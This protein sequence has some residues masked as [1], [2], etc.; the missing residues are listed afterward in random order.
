MTG[1]RHKLGRSDRRAIHHACLG[2]EIRNPFQH[3]GRIESSRQL[4]RLSGR[5]IDKALELDQGELDF[6][7]RLDYGGLK[8]CPLDLC[9]KNVV[10]RGTS[11]SLELLHLLETLTGK[12]ICGVLDS[13]ERARKQGLEIRALHVD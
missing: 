13:R 2:L 9:A 5:R 11:R 12:R 1:V 8:V 10:P 4:E 7:S 6:T 3:G